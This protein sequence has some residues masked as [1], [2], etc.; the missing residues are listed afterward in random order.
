MMGNNPDHQN[1]HAEDSLP[2]SESVEGYQAA[3]PFLKTSDCA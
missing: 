2:E 3:A 1:L